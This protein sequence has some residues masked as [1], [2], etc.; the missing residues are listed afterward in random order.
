MEVTKEYTVVAEMYFRIKADQITHSRKVFNF[1]D[2]LGTIGGV[3]EL[4]LAAIAM[5]YGGYAE[6]NKFIQNLNTLVVNQKTD[7]DLRR[8]SLSSIKLEESQ[9]VLDMSHWE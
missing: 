4:L 7:E 3:S 9:E 5:F 6:F 2:W 8:S 1:T